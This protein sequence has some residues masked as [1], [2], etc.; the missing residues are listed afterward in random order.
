[1]PLC[2]E[3]VRLQPDIAALHHNL[4]NALRSLKQFTDARAAF[5]ESLRLDPNLA[6]AHAHL[7]L[8]LQQEKAG[9]AMRLPGSSRRRNW[10][11]TTRRS[12]NTWRSCMASVRRMAKRCRAGSACCSS[13]RI[14]PSL[15]SRRQTG[16]CKRKGGRARRSSIAGSRCGSS[17]IMR[18]PNLIWP[19]FT[20]NKGSWRRRRRRVGRR[21]D[22][23]RPMRCLTADWRRC[24]AANCQTPIVPHSSSV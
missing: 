4:G 12:G 9:S 3:A 1:M 20:R 23:S 2:R 18:G 11:R 10:S 16:R 19:G 6:L 7:G 17:P 13:I 15:M 22:C 21:C 24:C 8:V 14:G 5:L